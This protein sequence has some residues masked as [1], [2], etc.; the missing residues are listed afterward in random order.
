MLNPIPVVKKTD[1]VVNFMYNV[2][3]EEHTEN[4]RTEK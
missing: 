2:G 4:S 3:K 1:Y